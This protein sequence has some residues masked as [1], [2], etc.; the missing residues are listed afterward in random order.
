MQDTSFRKIQTVQAVDA[1]ITVPPSKS[2][3][4]RALITA[5]LAEGSST[6]ITPSKAD[7]V[8]YLVKALEEFGVEIKRLKHW[9]KVQGTNGELKI[10]SKEIYVGNAGTTMRFLT[11]FACLAPGETVV[12]GDENMQNRPINDLLEALRS[13]GIKCSSINGCPPVKISGGSFRGGRIEIDASVSS[14]FVS[15]LLLSAPYA[16][17]PV[18]LYIKKKLSS[19]PYI[20]MSVHVMRS[21]GAEVNVI[22]ELHY[23]VKNDLRYMGREFQIEAD[24]SAATY[25]LA[26][27]AI[28]KG[29]VLVKNLPTES[30]QGDMKFVNVLSDMGCKVSKTETGIGLEGV[31]LKGIDVDMNAIPDCVPT[32]AVVAAF[33]EGPTTITNVHHLKYKETDRLKALATELTKLGVKVERFD[34]GFTIYPQ[35]LRGT[36]IETYNDHR[37]AMSFA[38]AGLKVDGVAIKNPSCVSKSFPNFWDEFNKLENGK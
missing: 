31:T 14:Q 32:L 8:E 10:P 37:M 36:T 15:S 23:E 25:F 33:A 4:N 20:D 38:I 28:T 26:A 17:Q 18:Y 2:Y 21:F 6:I 11:T 30:F 5:A 16:K 12:N 3:T 27:A 9:Y 22:D 35:S 1:E 13:T 7:D 24:A 34:D 29:R 19:L